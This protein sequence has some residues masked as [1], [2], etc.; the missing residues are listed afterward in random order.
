MMSNYNIIGILVD[1]ILHLFC[2]W[3][4]ELTL[5]RLILPVLWLWYIMSDCTK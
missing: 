5:I 3:K 4:L 1:L 2:T